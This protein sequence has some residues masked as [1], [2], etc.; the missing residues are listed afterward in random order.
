VRRHTDISYN[1][2]GS[3]PPGVMSSDAEL[4]HISMIMGATPAQIFGVLSDGWSYVGWVVDT[5][6]IQ[7]VD[8]T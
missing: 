5:T 1:T 7:G 8:A 2:T 4:T 3:R 6:H